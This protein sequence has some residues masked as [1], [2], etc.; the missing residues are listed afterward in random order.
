MAHKGRTEDVT[1]I[2]DAPMA[3]SDDL[4]MR[5]RRYAITM[6]IRT[7]CFFMIFFVHGWA[8]VV[9]VGLAAILPAI[10]VVLANARENRTP[11]Q[12]QAPAP[13]ETVEM[14][15]LTS[16]HVIRGEVDPHWDGR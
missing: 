16:G 8:R 3:H 9:C 2:T 6:I 7:T 15:M 11:P 12:Q 10:G 5:Q 1:V 14:P 13:S 4:E